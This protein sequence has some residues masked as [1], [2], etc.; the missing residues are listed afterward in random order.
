MA[1]STTSG[2]GFYEPIKIEE[3][4]IAI[5]TSIP[6]YTIG[7]TI[8]RSAYF[9]IVN[10]QPRFEY[11]SYYNKTTNLP[12]T[13]A[14]P[15]TDLVSCELNQ[16][17]GL[18]SFV[19]QLDTAGNTIQFVTPS[20]PANGLTVVN[21]TADYVR[22]T[23]IPTA[24]AASRTF[25][26]LQ[27]LLFPSGGTFHHKFEGINVIDDVNLQAVSPT[28]IIGSTP[29]SLLTPLANASPNGLVETTFFE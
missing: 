27:V 4:L 28:I 22:L 10:G 21:H 15:P 29:I 14:I 16:L 24:L 18:E 2:Q 13:A 17:R 12:I 9:S 25:G 23:I 3:C 11:N 1:T 20:R 26:N 8:T 5:N 19:T 7:D 6:D